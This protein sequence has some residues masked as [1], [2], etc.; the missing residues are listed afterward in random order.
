MNFREQIQ[1]FCKFQEILYIAHMKLD[2]NVKIR[3]TGI[4]KIVNIVNGK[5]YIGSALN[6]YNR[7]FGSSSISHLKALKNNNH[8]N[9]KLQNSFNKYGEDSFEFFIVEKCIKEELLIRE[10]YYLDTLCFAKNY[11]KFSKYSFNICPNAGSPLGKK[12]SNKTK[13]ILSISKKGNKNP[14]FG[15]T[16]TIL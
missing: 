10:Q 15:K 13:K 2:V 5:I 12:A 8:I 9:K 4:Y 7:I 1:K 6:I 3:I 14:M 16:I 11:K